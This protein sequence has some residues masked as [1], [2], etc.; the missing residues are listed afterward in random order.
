MANNDLTNRL[1]IGYCS[2]TMQQAMLPQALCGACGTGTMQPVAAKWKTQTYDWM[3]TLVPNEA[4]PSH[5]SVIKVGD[6][7]GS[8]TGGA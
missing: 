1:R 7:Y 8:S 6:Y 4:T 3:Y 2:S 5:N